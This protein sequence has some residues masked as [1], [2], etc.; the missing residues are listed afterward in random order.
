M[1]TQLANWAIRKIESEYKDDVCLLIGH[2][3]RE[4]DENN[5][6][7]S[8]GFYIPATSR[9]NGLARTFIID[10]IGY[11][12]FPMSWER[13]ERIADIKADNPVCLDDAEILYARND[14]DRR[15]FM[16]LQAQLRANLQN[17]HYMYN[18]ALELLNTA[19][20]I[21]QEMLF[22]DRLYK[23]REYA[24]YIC[25]HL[26]D[27]VAFANQRYFRQMQTNQIEELLSMNEIPAGFTDL[28]ESVIRAK[29]ADE[30]KRLC[31]KMIVS[32]KVFLA[33][34]DKNAVRRI[35]V[36]DFSELAFWYQELSY[37]WLRVY[38]WCDE[39]NP[40]NAYA[41]CCLLQKELDIVG[42]EYGIADLDIFSAFDAE[43]LSVFRK[44]AEVVE[45]N[46]VAAIEAN[47]AAI[48]SYPTVAD[49]LD[50]NS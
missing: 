29:T 44:R 17:P 6:E 23:V 26:S 31:H 5:D 32:T 49:F 4:F 10:G 28:Y 36:P 34:H 20:E 21:H 39:N 41:W 8:F 42:A 15:R 19:M 14:D 47:G 3:V 7:I 24:G 27:A 50:K 25:I 45:Q 11:D 16:A 38:H 30:Q 35:S 48:E 33:E 18:R 9:S 22:E 2:K 40:V 13:V 43:N 37:T 46:I 1:K 12:L